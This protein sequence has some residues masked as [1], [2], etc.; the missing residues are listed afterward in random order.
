MTT[1]TMTGSG[2]LRDIGNASIFGV[3]TARTGGDVFNLNGQTLTIDQDTRYGL[4][5]TT[6]T[7]L[8]SITVSA[9]LGGILRVDARYVRMVPVVNLT[10]TLT[11]GSLITCGG[12]T[13]RIIGSHIYNSFTTAPALSPGSP[14][15]WLKITAWNGVPFPTSGTYAHT[16]GSFDING[17]SIVG[18]IEVVGDE[19][20]TITA[21]RLGLVEFKG[22]WFEVGTTIGNRSDIYQLPT[23]GSA[24]DIPGVWVETAVSSN[25]YEFW[26]CAGTITATAANISP[27]DFRGKVCWIARTTGYLRFGSDG[28]NTTGGLLPEAGRKIRIPNIITANCTTA[29]RATNAVPNATLGTRY[30]FTTTGGGVLTFDKVNLAWYPSVS[31]AYSNTWNYVAVCD[32]LSIGENATALTLTETH[33]A[34]APT[35]AV[36]QA[37]SLALLP[38]GVTITNSSFTR[39]TVAAAGNYV[40]TVTDGAYFRASNVICRHLTYQSNA[41]TGSWS[42]TRFNDIEFTSG[43]IFQRALF[44]TCKDINIYSP[45]VYDHPATNTPS[46]T[47]RSGVDLVTCTNYKVSG[48]DN[49]GLLNCQPYGNLV[50]VSQQCSNGVV[51]N[52]GSYSTPLTLGGNETSATYTRA[53]TT[54]TVTSVGH[55]L[56]TGGQIYVYHTNDTAAITVGVKTITRT[57]N[58]VFTFTA[59]NAGA[60]SGA[61]TYI[62]VNAAM[63]VSSG[64]GSANNTLRIRRIYFKGARAS[65]MNIGDNSNTNYI[66]DNFV[67]KSFIT[68]G[69]VQS[70]NTTNKGISWQGSA[71]GQASVYGSHFID[72]YTLPSSASFDEVSVPWTRSS[73]TATVTLNNHGLLTTNGRIVVTVTSS[74]TAVTLGPKT[75]TVTGPN[76]FTFS[77]LAS[78]ATSGTLS[79]NRINGIFHVLLNEPTATTSSQVVLTGTANFTSAGSLSMPVINDSAEFTMPYFVKGHSRFAIDE[80]TYSGG[81]N[82]NFQSYYQLDTG[83][84]FS[85]T[86]KNLANTINSNASTGTTTITVADSSLISVGDYVFG[87]SINTNTKVTQILNA[88]QIQID[89]ATTGSV[90]N[91]LLRYN[92]LP[93]EVISDP[94][95]GFRLK[96]KVVTR[97]T[98]TQGVSALFFYTWSSDTARQYQYPL[99]GIQLTLTGLQTGSD[100]VVLQAGTSNVLSSVDSNAT[101]SWSYDYTTIENVDIG[102][103]KPGYIPLYIRNYSLG[104]S[105]ASLPVA[106]Q[107]DRNYA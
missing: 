16:G 89:R 46:T 87:T 104:A 1:Y 13:G 54:A 62:P 43:N 77:C 24:I 73:A 75:V 96:I 51:E 106:Q 19:G 97:A 74:E 94:S 78:G 82:T 58:D 7:S 47:G 71:T 95:T 70:L 66:L 101:S 63:P 39:L 86:W 11:A 45:I 29:A 15:A 23:N 53:T 42:F 49:G 91:Q 81:T 12:A 69:T 107:F 64:S 76:T 98:N 52:F 93:N 99:P 37:L 57:S 79:F 100:I 18:F 32:Q 41:G 36:Q 33:V 8:G 6:A 72:Y 21:N 103:I 92:Q 61:I 102:I 5:G 48:W 17:E 10:G 3:T 14:T 65:V 28:T 40:A 85:G 35:A 50:V 20:S 2:T 34:P 60:A 44:T 67:D 31:Q 84:G 26:P 9:T 56:I 55:G 22:E 80:L 30:D 105:N 88:T 27:N 83:S 59:L 68:G 90:T 4:S 38:T 25:T